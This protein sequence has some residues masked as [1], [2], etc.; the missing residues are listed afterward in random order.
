M[1]LIL[2]QVKVVNEDLS[3]VGDTHF[4]NKRQN[5]AY[6]AYQV[7]IMNEI[8]LGYVHQGHDTLGYIDI[9]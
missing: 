5:N 2:Y 8:P 1:T 6:Y 3:T 4:L 9:F 7:K